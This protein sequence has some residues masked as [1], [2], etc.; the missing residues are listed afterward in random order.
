[1]SA[2]ISQNPPGTFWEKVVEEFAA[3]I[4]EARMTAAQAERNI[5]EADRKQRR[6]WQFMKS[7]R[8]HQ[9]VFLEGMASRLGRRFEADVRKALELAS[10]SEEGGGGS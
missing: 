5:Q 7:S 6:Y 9:V 4:H 8:E 3:G 2:K 10:P 1:M